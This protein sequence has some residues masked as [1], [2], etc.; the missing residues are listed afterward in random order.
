MILGI[1]FQSSV[2]RQSGVFVTPYAAR[3]FESLPIFFAYYHWQSPQPPLLRTLYLGDWSRRRGEG[4]IAA[5]HRNLITIHHIHEKLM[6]TCATNVP[7]GRF[8]STVT[9]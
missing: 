7:L 2:N 3:P 6:S 9:L 8:S 4:S 5:Q 1:V